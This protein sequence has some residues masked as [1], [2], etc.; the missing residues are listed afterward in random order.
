MRVWPIVSANLDKQQDAEKYI[1]EAFSHR[2]RHDRARTSALAEP[3]LYGSRA[4]TST[5]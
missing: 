3:L 5:A 4:T 1:S 2:R